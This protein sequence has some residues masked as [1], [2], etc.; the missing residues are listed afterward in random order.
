M[1]IAMVIVMTARALAPLLERF[2]TRRFMAQRQVSPHTIAAYR[3]AFRRFLRFTSARLDRP[4][5]HLAFSGLDVSLAEA[6][7]DDLGQ[8]FS[9]TARSRNLR[10]STLRSLFRCA[11]CFVPEHIGHIQQILAIPAKRQERRLAGSLTRAEVDALLAAPDRRTWLGRRDHA[12]LLVAFQ[13]GLRLSEMTAL[14]RTDVSV[15]N[16]RHIR[17]IGKG[18]KRSYAA[19]STASCRAE[20]VKFAIGPMRTIGCVLKRSCNAV[21]VKSSDSFPISTACAGQTSCNA[22]QDPSEEEGDKESGD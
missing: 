22:E 8:R 20:P 4:P 3:D 9:S 19:C 15:N 18:R 6:F 11:A 13:T 1:P 17:C 14:R 21:C 12:W 16:A 10:L 5:A 2:F 7:L